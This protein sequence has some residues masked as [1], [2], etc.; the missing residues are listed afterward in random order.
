[1][2]VER[3]WALMEDSDQIILK[4]IIDVQLVADNVRDNL[5]AVRLEDLGCHASILV[6]SS[7]SLFLR[8]ERSHFS[9]S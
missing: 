4:Q 2:A 9:L 7:R 3:L 6:S 5:I 8:N 1:V